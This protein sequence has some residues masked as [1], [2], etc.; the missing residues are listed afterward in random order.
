MMC[1]KIFFFFLIKKVKNQIHPDGFYSNCVNFL[2]SILEEK[3][4]V[5]KGPHGRLYFYFLETFN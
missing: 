5:V 3:R 1:G 2:K 4:E